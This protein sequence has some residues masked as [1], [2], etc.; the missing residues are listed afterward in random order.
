M[1]GDLSSGVGSTNS[2]F[3][4]A[5]STGEKILEYAVCTIK[6]EA[7]APIAFALGYLMKNQHGEPAYFGWEHHGP[8]QVFGQK[9]VEMGYPRYLSRDS[10]PGV[11]NRLRPVS[12]PGWYPNNENK[13]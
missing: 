4:G 6:P 8:G 3:S 2:C 12:L 9:M 1:G 7:L 10:Q 11:G 5:N 13:R